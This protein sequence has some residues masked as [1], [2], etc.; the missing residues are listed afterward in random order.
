M[1]C[2]SSAR[3]ANNNQK[4][5]P[6]TAPEK[7]V[8]SPNADKTDPMALHHHH[9]MN[10]SQDDE[11]SDS[12]M[13]ISRSFAQNKSIAREMMRLEEMEL[14]KDIDDLLQN[15]D[16]DHHRTDFKSNENSEDI[17]NSFGEA[18][19]RSV[20]V[21]DAYSQSPDL[22][23]GEYVQHHADSY[24]PFGLIQTQKSE[25]PHAQSPEDREEDIN[26]LFEEEPT[27]Q[28]K[29]E[30][31]KDLAMD[32]EELY[33][34][35]F[36]Q[37]GFDPDKFR[38]ANNSGMSIRDDQ[39]PRESIRKSG[40]SSDM[41]SFA[42]SELSS[43][44]SKS[45]KSRSLGSLK[46]SVAGTGSRNLHIDEFIV[47][48]AEEDDFM[49]Q[50]LSRG[51]SSNQ[52]NITKIEREEVRGYDRDDSIGYIESIQHSVMGGGSMHNLMDDDDEELMDA[53]LSLDMDD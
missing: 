8:R 13:Q 25:S 19:T 15:V 52:F 20:T 22:E 33:A 7:N 42:S 4:E 27:I 47:E 41:S 44:T 11:S 3:S 24:T 40:G 16:E 26:R 31:I 50:E 10:A 43:K 21:E 45:S 53:I 28:T 39:N 29:G 51:A 46:S 37:N 17:R 12:S 2:C 36:K 5:D 38:N 30:K 23:K 34:E 1:G 35:N 48:E 9:H 18:A 6:V 49:L 32:L 14:G